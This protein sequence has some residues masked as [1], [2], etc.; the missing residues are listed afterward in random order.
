MHISR[1]RFGPFTVVGNCVIRNLPYKELAVQ[2][3]SLTVFFVPSLFLIW[4]ETSVELE[5]SWFSLT[6]GHIYCHSY[7]Y[8]SVFSNHQV[9]RVLGF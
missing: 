4:G 7:P 2:G 1:K 8:Y 9:S 6:K 5:P 3:R